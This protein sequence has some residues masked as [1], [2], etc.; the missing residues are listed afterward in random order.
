M[1]SILLSEGGA[2]IISHLQLRVNQNV[3]SRESL[4]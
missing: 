3:L 2:Y 1:P 4:C